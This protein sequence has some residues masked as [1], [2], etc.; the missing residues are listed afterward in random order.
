MFFFI[1]QLLFWCQFFV[2]AG[3]M[4]TTAI[5]K[6]RRRSSSR[7]GYDGRRMR[8]FLARRSACRGATMEIDDNISIEEIKDRHSITETTETDGEVCL[9]APT[10]TEDAQMSVPTLSLPFVRVFY[11]S[12]ISDASSFGAYGWSAS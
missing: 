1:F 7:S 5:P 12:T 9:G 4:R 8:A 11:Q 3:S 2:F 6:A 10:I